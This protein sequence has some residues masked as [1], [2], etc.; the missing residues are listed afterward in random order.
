MRAIDADRYGATGE[1]AVAE[2]AKVNPTHPYVTQGILNGDSGDVFSTEQ[3]RSLVDYIERSMGGVEAKAPEQAV[4]ED[5]V[6][7]LAEASAIKQRFEVKLVATRMPNA[8]ALA[9]GRVYVTRGLLD[10]IGTTLPP[11]KKIDANNDLL[12]HVLAHEL[13]HVIHKHT[14]HTA[15]F[16]QAIK[17]STKLL[18]PS[19]LTHVTRLHEIEADREG[20]V[21]AFLAGY[22][23]R[24]GIE[25]MELMGK[26]GEIPKHL[27]HPTF[28][29][30]IDYLTDFWTNDVRYAF[31]SFKLGV[32]EI[33]R[34][35]QLVEESDLPA[36]V[37]AYQTATEHF[38]RFHTMLPSLKEAMNDL[39][40][41]YTKLGVLAMDRNDSPLGRWQ[42]RFS[43]ERESS[44]KYANLV[45]DEGTRH[46]R[47]LD[48]ARL[49]SQLRD[50]IASF[51]EALADDEDYNNARLNLAAAYLAAG[52]LDNANAMLG[53]IVAQPDVTSGDVELAWGGLRRSEAV[54][55][56]A[57][58]LRARR[59]I[60]RQ[61]AR[62]AL[63]S[64]QGHGA[65]RQEGRRQEGLP[66]VCG[67][68]PGGPW[69]KAAETAA[70]KL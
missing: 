39:G 46:S 16:Q 43:L 59:G 60:P 32:A 56:G 37:A 66:A 67:R 33:D 62:R 64:R 38:K 49:P 48:R 18:D 69:A 23:P 5:I 65:G 2:L 55:G 1:R 42:T 10:T 24:G 26:Q 40:V 15:V 47:G 53:K 12:G 57:A 50:A 7:K 6:R 51:K 17:D 9:D 22:R 27:D 29:E 52:Q 68:L 70:A 58:G 41:A 61:P 4:L 25:F 13:N 11:G 20:M 21:M 8:F 35:D 63:Q 45:G 44:V 19:V 31:V 14:M 34:G 30:R 3:Y 54:R 36:A 28:Q